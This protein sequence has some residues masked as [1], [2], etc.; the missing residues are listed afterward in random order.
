MRLKVKVAVGL[1]QCIAA[2]PTVLNVA[3][4]PGLEHYIRWITL[5]EFPVDLNN[6][7]IP[8]ACFG[9]YRR[10]LLLGSSW[11]IIL[12]LCITAGCV[13]WEF[14]Q[15]RRK[16]GRSVVRP[17]NRALVSAGL[18]RPLPLMLPLTF[19]LVPSVSTRIF[20]TFLCNSFEQAP[21]TTRRYMQDDLALR[22]LR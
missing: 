9:S 11:P 16:K 17:S 3:P 8:S 10:R 22:Y 13:G 5:L 4:P 2:V 15:D 21:S 20:K 19:L 18:K 1:Y 14:A 6:I 7:A 12:L